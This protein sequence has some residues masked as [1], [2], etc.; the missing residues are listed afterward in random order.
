MPSG[1]R[2]SVESNDALW[3][4]L[5]DIVASKILYGRIPHIVDAFRIEAHGILP[6]LKST[7]LRGTVNVDPRTQDFFRVAIEEYEFHAES[8]CAD[9]NGNPC[10]KQ[11]IGL[12]QRRHVL[13][14]EINYIGK[15][16]NSLEEI[17]AGMIHSAQNV[18]TEYP[19]PR[20]DEWQTK[21]RPALRKIS[22]P[23]L[24]KESGL[25]RMMLI[26][27]RLGRTRPHRKNQELPAAIVKKLGLI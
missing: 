9:T 15:E 16:S 5:P 8:K 25:S 23:A 27:A 2:Y 17:E 14:D 24:Q 12:L 10:G 11:T 20:R 4:S 1:S 22:L 7:Q 3:F 6:G 19:D 18:Y 13:I 21:V 26:N